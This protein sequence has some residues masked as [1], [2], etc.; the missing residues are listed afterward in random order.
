MLTFEFEFPR[1]RSDWEKYT[2]AFL[3][4]RF[5][6]EK[7]LGINICHASYQTPQGS[8]FLR[9]G[10]YGLKISTCCVDYRKI[11]YQLLE[12]YQLK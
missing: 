11:V 6:V 3:A 5:Q 7:A 12:D 2:E 4:F 8:S 10:H 1:V 9:N